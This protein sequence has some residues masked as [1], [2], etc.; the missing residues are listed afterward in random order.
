MQLLVRLKFGLVVGG[1]L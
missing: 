1:K